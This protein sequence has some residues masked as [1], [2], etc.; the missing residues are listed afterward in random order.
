MKMK[1]ISV[2]N[3]FSLNMIDFDGSARW[4][5]VSREV[6]RD[7]LDDGHSLAPYLKSYIGHADTAAVIS[8]DLGFCLPANRETVKLEAGSRCLVCQYKGPRLPEGATSL[9][10]GATI[11]YYW[12]TVS[13]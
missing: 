2:L 12:L 1:H 6:L 10:D 8:A 4:N 11:E 3:A 5:R 13:L 7:M 9:P